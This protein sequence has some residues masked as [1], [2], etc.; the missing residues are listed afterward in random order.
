M[1]V[2]MIELLSS[3]EKKVKSGSDWITVRVEGGKERGG[4]A[5]W[6]W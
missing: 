2:L 3:R 4:K 1:G 6:D 5:E